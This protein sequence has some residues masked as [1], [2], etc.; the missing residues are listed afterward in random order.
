[1]IFAP[2]NATVIEFPL[3]PHIDRAYGYMAMAL[4]LDYWVVPQ[5]STGYYRNYTANSQNIAALC[6]LV[7]HIADLKQLDIITNGQMRKDS[8]QRKL[9]SLS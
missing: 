4:G 5:I 9:N 7:T 1:M 6:R 3:Q 8:A 2:R